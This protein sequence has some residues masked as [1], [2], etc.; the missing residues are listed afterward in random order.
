MNVLLINGSPRPNGCTA[1]ALGIVAQ[2][3]RHCGIDT[4][5]VNVGTKDI[6]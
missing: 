6:R 5:I 4:E 3:L 1:T 2:E